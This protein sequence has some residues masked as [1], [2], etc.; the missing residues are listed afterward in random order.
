MVTLRPTVPAPPAVTLC[1]IV[2][3]P[4]E[5]RLMFPSAAVV[6][7]PP[8]PSVPVFTT[9]TLPVFWLIPVIVRFALLVSATL[10]K[11]ALAALKLVIAFVWFSVCP[12]VELVVNN[13]PLITPPV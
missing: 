3:A 12:P 8:V 5:L 6:I 2:I 4:L 1:A 13:P 10:P 9:V 11:P 7:A